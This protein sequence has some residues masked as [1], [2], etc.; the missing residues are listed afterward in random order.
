MTRDIVIKMGDLIDLYDEGGLVCAVVTGEEKGRLKVVTEYGKELRVTS[1]RVA[2][3]AG[4]ASASGSQQAAAAA[5]RHAQAASARV[6]EIDLSA[7][8]DVLVDEPQRYP[9]GSL[10]ALALGAD[11]AVTRTAMLRALQGDRTYFTRKQDDFEPRPREQVEETHRREAA[12]RA[13]ADRRAAFIAVSYT[14]LRA[15][16]T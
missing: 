1:S 7:M 6:K 5:S 15:H 10:A 9:L 16:E 8:W 14:H 3:R 12:E 2:H 13:R 4:S 11:D